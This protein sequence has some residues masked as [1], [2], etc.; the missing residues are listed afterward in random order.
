MTVASRKLITK[1]CCVAA[2]LCLAA[3]KASRG[4]AARFK[5]RMGVHSAEQ[6]NEQNWWRNAVI[7]QVYPRSFQDTNGDG[8]G[9]LKGVIEHLDY[10]QK[11]GVDAIWLSPVY[12]SP[13][14]DFG[15]DVA[16]YRDIN[17][18]YGSMQDFYQL[19]A[20]AKKRNIRVIMDMVMN[21]TSDMNA[22]F[23]QSRSSRTNPY[24][25]WYIWRDGK[26][27]TA[28][29]KGQPPNNWGRSGGSSW[30]WDDKSRQY[31]FHSFSA[32]QIDLNWHNPAVHQEFKDIL[33]YWLKL[34]VAGFRFDAVG[35]LYKD[36]TFADLPAAK[37]EEGSRSSMRSAIRSSSAEEVS[38]QK[39]TPPCR[40]C[41]STLTLLIR[42]HFQARA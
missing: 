14:A 19:M 1:V 30:I 4:Q 27:E 2:L 21:H 7:Y 3:P 34:G 10:L 5:P 33:G 40:K 29:S 23:V 36:P 41:G 12:P 35:V 38:C 9:D 28:T 13:N 26:D 42:R 22:W 6:A 18:E 37:D 31:Y 17:P 39:W 32:Q 11:L 8:I 20:E 25:D 24:P 16:D 15:Y